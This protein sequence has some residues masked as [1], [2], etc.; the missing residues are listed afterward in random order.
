M[1]RLL[2]SMP[3]ESPQNWYITSRPWFVRG[4]LLSC[5]GAGGRRSGEARRGGG[6][7][8]GREGLRTLRA[9]S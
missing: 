9:L 2:R 3:S 8:G 7:D 5:G 6:S 4:V 1:A